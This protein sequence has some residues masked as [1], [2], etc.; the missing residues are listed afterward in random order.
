MNN[1]HLNKMNASNLAIVF[2]PNL[3][4]TESAV[5]SHSAVGPINSIAKIIIENVPSIFG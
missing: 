1:A 2:G 3:I 4:W 5:A